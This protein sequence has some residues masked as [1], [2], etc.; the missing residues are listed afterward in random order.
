MQITKLLLPQYES[1][2]CGNI[3]NYVGLQ[4]DHEIQDQTTN[5]KICYNY[6]SLNSKQKTDSQVDDEKLT[7]SINDVRN[8][9]KKILSLLQKEMWSIYSFKALERKLEIH[10][11]SLS[12]AL[13]RLLDLNLIEKTSSGYKLVERNVHNSN[14]ILEDNFLNEEIEIDKSKKNRKYKQLIQ[15]YMPVKGN[16]ELIVDHLTGKWFGNL[17]WFGL[18]K[19]ET[20]FRLQWI[21]VDKHSNNKIFQINVSILSEYII[22]ESDA[23]TDSEKV[24]AMHH[25][26]RI[27]EE[28]IKILQENLHEEFIPEKEYTPIYANDIKFSHNRNN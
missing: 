25:S 22:V 2:N 23:V 17:R 4:V 13:K 12:R 11:Q 3:P 14:P 20:G 6:F 8:N 9:D 24:E 1:N 21:V 15:I 10:Q 28:L 5:L 19:K 18:I 16:I 26:N 27:I 7:I